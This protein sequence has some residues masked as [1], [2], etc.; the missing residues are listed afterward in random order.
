MTN[1]VH[2]KNATVSCIQSDTFCNEAQQRRE[3]RPGSVSNHKSRA[4]LSI[5][6]LF[7]DSYCVTRHHTALRKQTKQLAGVI[8]KLGM[9]ML[10]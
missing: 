9:N 5:P 1:S 8:N 7:T 6:L 10:W 3:K 2:L 4:I